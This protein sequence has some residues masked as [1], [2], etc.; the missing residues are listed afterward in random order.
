M[1]YMDCMGYIE[2]AS[3]AMDTHQSFLLNP[4]FN[5]T[6]ATYS[7]GGL[8]SWCHFR[9]LVPW[10]EVEQNEKLEILLM[11]EIR[12]SPVEVGSLSHYLRLVLCIPGGCLGFL[13]S[14]VGA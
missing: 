6:E 8:V 9:S 5:V 13:S 1:P 14:I 3:F 2:S 11:E 12:R 4:W 7:G 10:L